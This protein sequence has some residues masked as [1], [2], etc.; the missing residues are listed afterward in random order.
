MLDLFPN[1]KIVLDLPDAI[2]EYY[3]NFLTQEKANMI[4]QKLL[5]ETP[6]KQDSITIYGKNHLQPRLTA[7]YGNEGKPY[8]YS[9]IVMQ[10]HAWNPTLMFLK[11]EIEE[12]TQLSFTT[13]LLNL[14]RDE[15]DSNGWHSDN[16]KE[17]G[18][19]PTIASLSLGQDR[20]FQIKH[21][22]KKEI[23]Q[24]IILTNGS[25][26]VMKEGSQIY[27]KHQ[28]PKASSPKRSRINLT[29]RTII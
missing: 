3:P 6:W 29:F 26:L 15:N 11:N 13:V 10:P 14:Y 18:R 4:Y 7:L 1:E 8:S 22:E 17:L 5:D 16:E 21:I 12:H 20:V 9:N 27:Y 28:L 24:N 23:K 19:N 25:L 2:F